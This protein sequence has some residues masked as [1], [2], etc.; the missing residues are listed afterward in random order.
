LNK[1]Y[2]AGFRNKAHFFGFSNKA[3]AST[4]L[5]T[6]D[7]WIIDSGATR[8]LTSNYDQL[9]DFEAYKAISST[10]G[11]IGQIDI[12]G[13]GKLG[14]RCIGTDNVVRTVSISGVQYAPK[15][16]CQL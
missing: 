1:A 7:S 12:I 10:E 16:N 11:I 8:H 13:E 2:T 4:Q 5:D 14:L 3:L 9:Y 6:L 15:A